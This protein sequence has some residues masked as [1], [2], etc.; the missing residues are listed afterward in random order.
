MAASQE[1]EGIVNRGGI[2]QSDEAVQALIALGYSEADAQVALDEIDKTL[3]S[4]DRI[5]Q[6]LRDK[7]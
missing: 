4:E 2:D 1:A 5:K 3:P 6:A 7:Q